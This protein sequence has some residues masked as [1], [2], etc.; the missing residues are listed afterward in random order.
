MSPNTTSSLLPDCQLQPFFDDMLANPADTAVRLIVMDTLEKYGDA[1]GRLLRL[2]HELTQGCLS[3]DQP[4]AQE[5]ELRDLLQRGVYPVGPYF[6]QPLIDMW[7][8]LIPPNSR[9]SSGFFLGVYP[10]TQKQW[11]RVMGTTPSHF[12][13]ENLPVEMVSWNDCQEFIANLQKLD[14]NNQY[15]LPSEA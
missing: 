15:C 3:W 7:F 13:G 14:P 1:R 10:V 2:L 12:R 4:Q 6:H 8:A 11:E 9:L 5:A